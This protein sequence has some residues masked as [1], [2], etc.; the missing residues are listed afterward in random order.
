MK[1]ATVIAALATMAIVQPAAAQ[2]STDLTRCRGIAE[3]TQRLKCYDDLAG[4]SPAAAAPAG[5]YQRIDINDLKVDRNQMRG[6]K[7]ETLG[8]VST[9]GEMVVLSAGQMDTS[10][11]F[12]DA[13]RVPRDQR[14][15]LV[16]QCNLGCRAMI[17]GTIG[18][19]MMQAGVLAESISFQ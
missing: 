15:K 19:V 5:E 8:R 1:L 4:P 7:I 16:E 6:K 9:M 17:R 2:S 13:T 10:P 18:T 11:I 3:P 12:V 14:R